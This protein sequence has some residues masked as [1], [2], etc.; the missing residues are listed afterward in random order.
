M[1]L[2]TSL[3]SLRSISMIVFLTVF[4]AICAVNAHAEATIEYDRAKNIFTGTKSGVKYEITAYISGMATF[5]EE[6]GMIVRKLAGNSEISAFSMM[7]RP[8]G[9]VMWFGET[10]ATVSKSGDINFV[11]VEPMTPDEF[12]GLKPRK[13]NKQGG[14]APGRISFTG[15]LDDMNGGVLIPK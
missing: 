6:K 11:L 14:V 1:N 2:V 3:A 5:K 9:S 4:L 8:D 15:K 7:Q 10:I 13:S 12:S